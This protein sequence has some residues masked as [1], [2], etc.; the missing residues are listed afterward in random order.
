MLMFILFDVYLIVYAVF[1]F[2]FF[3]GTHSNEIS[4]GVNKMDG[5]RF[6]KHTSKIRYSNTTSNRL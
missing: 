5:S 4:K 1:Y 6:R 2:Y 3:M